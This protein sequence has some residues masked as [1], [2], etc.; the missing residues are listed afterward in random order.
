[1]DGRLK[2]AGGLRKLGVLGDPNGFLRG[3]GLIGGKL[4]VARESQRIREI[5]IRPRG[6][7]GRVG[8]W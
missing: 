1:M 2:S 8:F 6:L 4:T 7:K 5:I 3:V